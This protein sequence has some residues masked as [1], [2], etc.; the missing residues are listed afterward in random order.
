M[1]DRKDNFLGQEVV[2]LKAEQEEVM[3]KIPM[4]LSLGRFKKNRSLI[5]RKL[6][7]FAT[8]APVVGRASKFSESITARIS[9]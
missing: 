5:S 9:Y 2:M 7:V 1:L 6:K 4:A 3:V 8:I